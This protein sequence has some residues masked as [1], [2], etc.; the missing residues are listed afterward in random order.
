MTDQMQCRVSEHDGDHLVVVSG[1]VDLA[2][3]PELEEVLVQFASGTVTVDLTDVTF[4]DSS[5]LHAFVSAHHHVEQ[6]RSR[7]IVQGVTP[8]PAGSS[9]SPASTPSCAPTRSRCSSR[10]GR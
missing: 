9:R 8:T 6:R 5:G 1:E 7:L 3:A 10:I 2:T 4:I